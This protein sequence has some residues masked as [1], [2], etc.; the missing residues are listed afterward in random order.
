MRDQRKW[1]GC[2]AVAMVTACTEAPRP[3]QVTLEV[4]PDGR[5]EGVADRPSLES[6]HHLLRVHRSLAVP[7]DCGPLAGVV[8][9]A[10]GELTLRIAPASDGGACEAPDTVLAY[11]ATI[12]GLRPGR[13]N[14]RVVHARP[15]RGSDVVFEHP[16]LVVDAPGGSANQ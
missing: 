4:H 6:G 11:T 8:A 3:P 12:F 9:A 1:I 15:G 13:Y 5:R 10:A 14:L 2:L 16:V 7:I